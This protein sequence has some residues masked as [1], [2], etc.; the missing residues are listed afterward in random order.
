MLNREDQANPDLF[1]SDSSATGDADPGA[2]PGFGAPLGSATSE[3]AQPRTDRWTQGRDL[4]LRLL[5][6]RLRR[7]L[8]KPLAALSL[9]LGVTL[10]DGKCL[11]YGRGARRFEVMI[12]NSAGLW[13][14]LTLS[15]LDIAEAYVRDDLDLRGDLIA[16]LRLQEDLGDPHFLTRIWSRLAPAMVGRAR[17]NGGWIALHY[18]ANNLQ[19]YAADRD[20][21]TYTEGIYEGEDDTLEAGAERKL[22]YAFEQLRLGPGRR[23][24]DVGS[25]WGGF[26]RFAGRRG[27]DFTG[28]TLSRHQKAYCDEII[29][30]EGLPAR[31]L[32]QD[33]FTYRPAARFDAISIMGVIEDLSDYHRVLARLADWIEPGGRVYLDFASKAARF[34]TH[35]FITKHVWPGT[36]RLVYMPEFIDAVRESPFELLHLENDRRNYHLWTKALHER[37][38][39]NRAEV[40]A[41]SSEQ[42]WR[43]YRLLFATTSALMNLR[44]HY[45]TAYR[46]VLERPLDSDGSWHRVTA[47]QK[48][49][50]LRIGLE[51][52]R[53]AV[54]GR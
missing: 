42:L 10:P 3:G 18:D 14:L 27:V 54:F 43:L 26:L 33:F 38:M 48:L 16:A 37:W 49:R 52:A 7:R 6:R 25:G 23:L 9:S 21:F 39:A 28:I 17:L 50:R 1:Y 30:R 29:A 53:D 47:G 13:A 31:V 46:V 45:A 12:R 36:F 8:E 2:H 24:L 5:D 11:H 19:A 34:S 44:S 15:G 22:G 51:E 4:L 32:Y 41:R 40:V 20:Y 35:S